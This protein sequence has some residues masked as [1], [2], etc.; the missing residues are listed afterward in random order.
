MVFPLDFPKV[1]MVQL[2]NNKHSF[3]DETFSSANGRSTPKEVNN[4]K[5]YEFLEVDQKATPEEIRKAYRKKAM[6]LHP[7]KGGD[8]NKVIDNY[9]LFSSKSY[10]QLMKYCQTLRK[11]TFMTNTE[12]KA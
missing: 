12:R 3:L 1:A 7:D 4:K 5:Y 2:I 6:K 10:K 11:E 9:N 8:Q